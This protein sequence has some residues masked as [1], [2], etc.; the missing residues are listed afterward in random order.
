[1][2]LTRRSVLNRALA[3]AATSA[4]P[5]IANLWAI[6][7]ANAAGAELPVRAIGVNCFDLFYSTIVGPGVRWGRTP[8]VRL[9]ELRDAGIP[10]VRFAASPFWTSE[11]VI[12]QTNPE[13]YFQRMDVI[14]RA[15]ER[16]GVGLIPSLFWNPTSVSDLMG[17]PVS[18]WGQ[19][20]S[21][22]R[23]FMER[24][25]SEVVGRYKN[26]TALWMWEFGNEFN[27]YADLP[28]A[29]NWWPKS[30]K[31]RPAIVRT[32]ADRIGK[33][34]L[35]NIFRAFGTSVRRLD[36]LHMITSGADMPR[37]NAYNLAK[38]RFETDSVDELQQNLLDITPKPL[39]V[40]S[41]HFYPDRKEKHLGGV[42]NYEELLAPIVQAAERAGKRVFVGEFGVPSSLHRSSEQD[43]FTAMLKALVDTGVHYAAV[44]VYDYAAQANE[45]SITTKGARAY[46]LN[47]IAQ[48]NDTLKTQAAIPQ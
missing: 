25:V 14:F 46:Q 24:Y 23:N 48:A 40:V 4:I 2:N 19:A 42:T 33:S 13:H 12:Y 41:V 36:A 32:P 16:A 38:G 21:R 39:N 7:E 34:L 3:F 9:L 17:E 35:V 37:H 18:A 10:F 31:G 1:M 29:L 27:T 30:E 43:E 6:N 5:G 26:S 45:W 44:W 28:N 8:L 11:W 22:T 15:A 47:L 20:G